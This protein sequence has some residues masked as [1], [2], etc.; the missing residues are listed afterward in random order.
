MTIQI[1]LE[2]ED[3]ILSASKVMVN[4]LVESLIQAKVQGLPAPQFRILDMVYH[5]F[6]KPA[7]VAKMLDVSPSATTWLLE[8][9][10]EK[11]FIE[12]THSSS[13]R[14]RVVLELTGMGK[15]VVRRVNAHR[16]NLL[17]KVLSNMKERA[18]K[19]LDESLEA[20]SGSYLQ[21]KEAK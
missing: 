9:L 1:S 12:R 16:R 6:D 17:G 7:D 19:Q 18:V 13:D 5:G 10:E 21:L 20:F 2:L 11:G 3:K 8:R 15:D 4:I 14:R